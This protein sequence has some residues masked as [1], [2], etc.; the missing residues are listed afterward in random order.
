V[1][2]NKSIYVKTLH[3]I[4]GIEALCHQVGLQLDITFINDDP[5]AKMDLLKKKLKSADRIFWVEYGVSV[6]KES[7][8]NSVIKYDNHDGLVFPVVKEGIDWDV[9]RQKCKD[10]SD[11]PAYQM[12]L[13]FDTDVSN[14]IVNKERNLY[15]VTQTDPYCWVL[16]CKRVMRKLTDKNKKKSFVF[17]GTIGEFFKKCTDRNVRLAASVDSI[18]YNHFTHECVGNIMNIPGLTIT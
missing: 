13:T 5:N 12:G 18:T 11:E 1:S 3:S 16:D 2:K 8:I 17:P 14:R 4:L 6:N 7:L 10:N 9:F 15:E